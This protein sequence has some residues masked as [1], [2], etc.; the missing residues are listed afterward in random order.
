MT[1]AQ[2][3]TRF[4]TVI[5]YKHLTMLSQQALF[6]ADIGGSRNA[7]DY[8]NHSLL[9]FCVNLLRKDILGLKTPLRKCEDTEAEYRFKIFYNEQV[10]AHEVR[11]LFLSTLDDHPITSRAIARQLRKDFI[12]KYVPDSKSRLRKS[13]CRQI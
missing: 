9:E 6:L 2:L 8:K 1:S 11:K 7:L 10:R 3:L 13:T 4:V 5:Q 12:L